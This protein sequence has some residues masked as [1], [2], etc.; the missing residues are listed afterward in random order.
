MSPWLLIAAL[1][2]SGAGRPAPQA[3]KSRPA[4]ILTAAPTPVLIL[5]A[6]PT[7]I[8]FRAENPDSAPAPVSATVNWTADG[9]NKTLWSLS[10]QSATPNFSLCPTVPLSAVTV[11][12]SSLV[13][14][15]V[16]YPCSA[17]FPLSA[18]PQ[19]LVQLRAVKGADISY[20]VNLL[21]SWSDSWKYIA[22]ANTPCSVSITY[23]ADFN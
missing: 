10:A 4:V 21:L 19:Y 16:T 13:I 8:V 9:K 18:A 6:S 1:L 3:S 15:G 17:S 12:C 11:T 2:A 20:A 14:D 7:D 5:T 23:T 22:Q